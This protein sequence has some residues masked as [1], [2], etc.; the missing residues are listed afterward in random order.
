MFRTALPGLHLGDTRGIPVGEGRLYQ[1]RRVQGTFRLNWDMSRYPFDRHRLTISFAES[2]LGA[3]L[4]IFDVDASSLERGRPSPR[5]GWNILA[6]MCGRASSTNNPSTVAREAGLGYARFEASVDLRRSACAWLPRRLSFLVFFLDPHEKGTFGTKL[7]L[8]V[9]VLFAVL[10][11]LRAADALIGDA[12]SLTLIP[13]VHLVMMALIVVIALLG[14]REQTRVESGLPLRYPDGRRHRRHPLT[15]S[16]RRTDCARRGDWCATH[17]V[18]PVRSSTAWPTW[19]A[20]LPSWKAQI[21]GEQPFLAPPVLPATETQWPRSGRSRRRTCAPCRRSITPSC[22][23]NLR[24]CESSDADISGT[25]RRRSLKRV[26][27]QISSR[28]TK[29]VSAPQGPAPPLAIGQ[30]RP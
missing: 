15:S 25:P 20:N 16:R 6:W 22:L 12:T 17:R 2:D 13:E 1:Y 5:H 10:L 7:V 3:G 9:G 23:R 8:L 21:K 18:G 24:R 28:R 11:N 14:L 27:P 4:V 26:L 29:G 30:N 19:G